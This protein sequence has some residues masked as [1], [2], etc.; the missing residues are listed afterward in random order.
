MHGAWGQQQVV[1]E[2]CQLPQLGVGRRRASGHQLRQALRP[3]LLASVV[4]E[5]EEDPVLVLV[6]LLLVWFLQA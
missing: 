1:R 6:G 4:E 2:G 5:V 3:L